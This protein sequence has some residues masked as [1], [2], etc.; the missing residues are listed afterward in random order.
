MAFIILHNITSQ[1]L[2]YIWS[3]AIYRLIKATVIP[4]S[5][6]CPQETGL[7]DL[8]KKYDLFCYNNYAHTSKAIHV[9]PVS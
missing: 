9:L 8:C 3:K 5:L 6:S 2:S 1:F 4:R 7:N